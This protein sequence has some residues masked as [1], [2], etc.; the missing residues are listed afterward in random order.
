MVGAF[1][2]FIGDPCGPGK[3]V[4]D[5]S[6]PAMLGH[7]PAALTG[8][9]VAHALRSVVT[10]DPTL[11]GRARF[12]Q[13]GIALDVGKASRLAHLG[14][15]F[16]KWSDGCAATARRRIQVSSKMKRRK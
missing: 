4:A 15:A 12:P 6:I 11:T 16:H 13:L 3:C 5:T 14:A 10:L 7:L 2:G 8:S 9:V 1:A